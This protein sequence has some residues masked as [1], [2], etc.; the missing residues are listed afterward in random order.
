MFKTQKK[1]DGT[2]TVINYKGKK[3]INTK[4]EWDTRRKTH[5]HIKL[6]RIGKTENGEQSVRGYWY[7]NKKVT[8]L[9]PERE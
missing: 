1:K 2:I 8:V 7:N 3:E 5:L 9:F 4:R 6:K